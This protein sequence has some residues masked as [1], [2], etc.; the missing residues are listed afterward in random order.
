M[1]GGKVRLFLH[2]ARIFCQLHRD[3]WIIGIQ[4]PWAWSFW[5]AYHLI[6]FVSSRSDPSISGWDKK[7][8][9]KWAVWIEK[10]ALLLYRPQTKEDLLLLRL[11]GVFFLNLIRAEWIFVF[12]FPLDGYLPINQS[13]G[14]RAA[15][16]RY[17]C[18]LPGLCRPWVFSWM[19]E[20]CAVLRPR[21]LCHD[22]VGSWR[23]CL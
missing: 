16:P 9:K 17:A 13:K 2:F 15:I 19:R 6:S 18:D 8:P 22:V 5:T 23:F 3:L 10:L 1:F 7:R 20:H 11:K 12:A 21:R 4:I 14:N